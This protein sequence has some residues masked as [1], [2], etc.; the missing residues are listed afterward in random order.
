MALE[1]KVYVSEQE[2]GEWKRGKEIVV[3]PHDEIREAI[4]RLGK[5][6]DSNQFDSHHIGREYRFSYLIHGVVVSYVTSKNYI[7]LTAN[8]DNR[9]Q[10]EEVAE[11]LELPTENQKRLKEQANLAGIA[12]AWGE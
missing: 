10:I 2:K 11:M 6:Q 7:L 5:S 12:G 9:S 1:T 3:L 8:T 4:R